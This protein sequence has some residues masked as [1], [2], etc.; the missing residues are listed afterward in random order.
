MYNWV[1][2]VSLAESGDDTAAQ[3][4]RAAVSGLPAARTTLAEP[5]LPGT[6]NGGHLICR[7]AF[8]SVGDYRDSV[9]GREGRAVRALLDDPTT[10]SGLDE[11]TY[12]GGDSGGTANIP[13]LYRVALFAATLNPTEAR[14]SDFRRQTIAMPRHVKTIQR[15]QLSTTDTASGSN[16][17]TH[18]WEQEYAD[19]QGLTGAYMM[20]PVHWSN[21]ERWFDP[22]YP[23]WLVDRPL[24]H[25]FCTIGSSV[26][27]S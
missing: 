11:V 14:L 23:E 10:V 13:T 20:H 26:I 2:V 21:V 19:L 27:V 3:A 4:I 7:V 8:D 1:A 18:V 12:D 24:V 16:R 5:T 25:T 22:E 6:L 15:W 9:N 17:W